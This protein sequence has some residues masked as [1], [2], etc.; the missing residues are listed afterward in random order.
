MEG[1]VSNFIYIYVYVYIT[2]PC[3]SSCFALFLPPYS[4]YRGQDPTGTASG[5][6]YS[7]KQSGSSLWSEPMDVPSLDLAITKK[8]R[9]LYFHACRHVL[10]IIPCLYFVTCTTYV[11][12]VLC[13]MLNLMCG[14]HFP[15][16]FFLLCSL[17]RHRSTI[18][19]LLPIQAP[20][21]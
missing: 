7:T 2:H 20:T 9:F 14:L 4:L 19:S 1:K 12:R 6:A 11:P 21:R 18:L 8:V 3:V 13:C 10:H 15:F 16:S 5:M 17:P